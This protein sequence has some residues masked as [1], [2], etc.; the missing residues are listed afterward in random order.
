MKQSKARTSSKTEPLSNA[1]NTL[2]N[3]VGC[4]FYLGCQ[5]ATTVFVAVLAQNYAD[6]GYLAFA[7]SIGN[8]YSSIAL[9]KT[10][11]YQVSDIRKKYDEGNYIA[12][13]YT[14]TLIALVAMILYVPATVKS[15]DF[16]ASTVAYI[17]FKLDESFT[18][19]YHGILQSNS[20]MD[21]IGKS[22]LLRGFATLAGFMGTYVAFRSLV[23][24]TLTMTVLC[25]LVTQCYDKNCARLF[26]STKPIFAAGHILQL[27]KACLLPMLASLFANSIVSIARQ[28][29]GISQGQ[30]MLG[31]YASIA[32][33]SVI[34]QVAASYLYTPLY[35]VLA[36]ELSK[37][38]KAFKYAF[39]KT[40][41]SIIAI[42]AV[43]IVLLSLI[44][45][46]LLL[47]LYGADIKMYLY[48]FPFVLIATATTSILFFLNDCL[49]IMRR[50]KTQLIANLVALLLLNLAIDHLVAVYGMN[51][52]NIAIIIATAIATITETIVLL[53][54]KSSKA[55]TIR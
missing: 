19:V 34:V 1:A 14:T 44:G 11:P 23:T 10:R 53:S 4:F 36:T 26:C 30:E 32:T 3:A 29:Y 16:V 35:T 51:G 50:M 31:I 40:V 55:G 18:D 49:I 27:L 15:I 21:Y 45:P 37:S 13:R 22:E 24:S 25:V 6:A 39:L 5:W 7:M 20:R 9:F 54:F 47:M 43:L 12:F 46:S 48:I 38:A 33:P 41:F 8:I 42:E 17:A 52:L 2:W 28:R